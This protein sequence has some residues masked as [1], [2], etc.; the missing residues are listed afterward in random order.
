M[1][2]KYTNKED[3]FHDEMKEYMEWFYEGTQPSGA[4]N[5]LYAEQKYQEKYNRPKILDYGSFRVAKHKY[6][7]GIRNKNSR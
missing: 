7:R 1:K 2:L 5:H 4:K 3:F 6:E